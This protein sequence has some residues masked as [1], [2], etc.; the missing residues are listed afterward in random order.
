MANTMSGAC[1]NDL[2]IVSSIASMTAQSGHGWQG[3]G[4]GQGANVPSRDSGHTRGVLR[5]INGKRGR[6]KIERRAGDQPPVVRFVPEAMA[7]LPAT[8]W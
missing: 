3:M 2:R 5:G 4:E 6:Q 7:A 8:K 1:S